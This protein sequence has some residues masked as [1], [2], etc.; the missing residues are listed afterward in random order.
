MTPLHLAAEGGHS[1][2][3]NYLLG[4]G[5]DV[6]IRDHNGVNYWVR[7]PSLHFERCCFH[8]SI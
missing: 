8:L 4:Q 6:N 3:V 7:A 5:A 1:K 2:V